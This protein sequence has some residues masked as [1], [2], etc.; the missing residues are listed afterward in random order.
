MKPM[1]QKMVNRRVD[2]LVHIA[3]GHTDRAIEKLTSHSRRLIA[4]VRSKSNEGAVKTTYE[5]TGRPSK[6]T[7]EVRNTVESITFANPRMGNTAI[8][9]VM[10]EPPSPTTYSHELIRQIRH[11]LGYN[12]LPP[13]TRFPLTDGQIANR[14]SFAEHHLSVDTDWG[15][16]I[17]STKQPSSLE[18]THGGFGG[19][20]GT[21]TLAFTT[22]Q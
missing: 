17:L 4:Q 5:G 21:R 20:E 22:R 19:N 2:I 1:T 3:N 14:L 13:I 6:N 18:Q 11:D 16:V 10:S 7:V 15:T 12:F 9:S 8:A